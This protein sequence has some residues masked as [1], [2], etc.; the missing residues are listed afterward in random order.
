MSEQTILIVEDEPAIRQLI[1]RILETD[2][3]QSEQVESADAA[4]ERLRERRYDLILLDLH[5]PG[6][7]D[8]EE[9]LFM[10]RDEGENVPIIIVSGWVDDEAA[11]HQ[12]DCVYAVIKKPIQSQLLLTRVR[13]VLSNDPLGEQ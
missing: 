11:I 1:A 4:L 10:V 2:G 8:G 3:Y 6:D 9:F 12:P 7:L 13:E 5:M